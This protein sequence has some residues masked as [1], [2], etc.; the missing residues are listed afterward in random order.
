VIICAEFDNKGRREIS[1]FHGFVT[2]KICTAEMIAS[3]C[4]VLNNVG[5]VTNGAGPRIRPS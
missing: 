4:G 1:S 2:G 3:A 5:V